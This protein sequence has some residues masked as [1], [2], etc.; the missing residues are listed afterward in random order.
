[1]PQLALTSTTP[2]G[3]VQIQLRH[4]PFSSVLLVSAAEWAEFGLQDKETYN[5]KVLVENR[6]TEGCFSF[7]WK[8]LVYDGETFPNPTIDHSFTELEVLQSKRMKYLG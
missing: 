4:A 7:S 2:V 8:Y 1:M 6:S 3:S 5:A